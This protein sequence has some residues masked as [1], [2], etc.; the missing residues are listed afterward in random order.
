[1]DSKQEKEQLGC[2]C[3]GRGRGRRK[4]ILKMSAVEAQPDHLWVV[5]SF[6][7]EPGLAI[8]LLMGK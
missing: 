6:A 4:K 8:R 1:M 7:R 2:L 3:R 5:A